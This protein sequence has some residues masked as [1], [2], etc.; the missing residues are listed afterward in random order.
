MI[1][2]EF[3]KCPLF[4]FLSVCIQKIAEQRKYN[5]RVYDDHDEIE[6]FYR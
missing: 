6:K 4:F 3:K 1:Y 5:V 2:L